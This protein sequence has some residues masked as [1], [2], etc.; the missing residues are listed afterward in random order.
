MFR[1]NEVVK[2]DDKLYRILSLVPDQIV[3]ICIDDTSAFPSLVNMDDLAE[4][5]DREALV[6]AEDPFAKLAY[7]T[8]EQGSAA[9]IKRDRNYQIIKPLIED[10]LYYVP[11]IRSARINEIIVAEETTKV[12]LYK[13]CRRYWQRGQTPNTLIP[14][15][16]NSG[17]KGK[18]R[19]AKD[20]KLGRPRKYT[21]G[22]GALVDEQIERLF[23]I[24]INKYVLQDKGCTF[25]FAHRR[26]K[27]LC[28]TYYPDTS[29]TE[30]ADYLA[31]V[32]FLQARI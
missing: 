6:R 30:N 3:W 17:G 12:T 24:A 20:K 13:I 21:P 25:P 27:A 14:D 28:E 16:Q 22:V 2:Y 5:I 10:P 29:E 18:K 32:T 11:K 26:F 7:L 1:I 23:R 15:Y 31:N 4:A 9:Q 8:P 19:I